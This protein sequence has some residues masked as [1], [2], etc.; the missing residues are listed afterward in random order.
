ME[1]SGRIVKIYFNHSKRFKY[2]KLDCGKKFLLLP[3]QIERLGLSVGM[4]L[5]VRF[6]EEV[7][8]M[9]IWVDNKY[10]A[11]FLKDELYKYLCGVQ[12]D[13]LE[14]GTVKKKKYKHTAL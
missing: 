8:P 1:L 14:I 13:L 3:N 6:F 2:I 9:K 11:N 4:H 7:V 5:K 10:V 12:A